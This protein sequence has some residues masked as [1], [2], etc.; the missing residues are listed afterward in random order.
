[1]AVMSWAANFVSFVAFPLVLPSGCADFLTFCALVVCCCT[2]R[3]VVL[4]VGVNIAVC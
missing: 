3:N 4:G 2:D 1:M